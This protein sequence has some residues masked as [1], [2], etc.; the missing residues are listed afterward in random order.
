V[1]PEEFGM[2]RATLQDIAGGDAV[3]NAAI[4]RAILGGEKSPRRNVVVLNAAAALVAAGRSDHVADAVAFAAESI[5]SGAA[6]RKLEKL[7]E[8]SSR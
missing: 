7:I 2:T 6:E 8:F 5:D 1:E 3:E 4:I